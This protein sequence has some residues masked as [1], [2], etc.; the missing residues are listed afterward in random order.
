MDK[1]EFKVENDW[2]LSHKK[3]KIETNQIRMIDRV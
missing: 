1:R 2:G 3:E